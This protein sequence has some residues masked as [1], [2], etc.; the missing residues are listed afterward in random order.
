MNKRRLAAACAL[1]LAACAQLPEDGPRP[2]MKPARTYTAERSL[3]APAAQWPT[4]AWWTA[5]GDPQLD[6]LI[7]EAVAGSPTLASAV[8][9]L[10]RAQSQAQVANAATLPQ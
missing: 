1:A 9:R 6:A 7:A 2:E 3:A 10:H 5:Y 4:E 8:A